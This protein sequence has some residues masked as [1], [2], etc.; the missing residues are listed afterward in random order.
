MHTRS[1]NYGLAGG[2][3]D[4]TKHVESAIKRLC[5]P[6]EKAGHQ[7]RLALLVESTTGVAQRSAAPNN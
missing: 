5:F 4:A 6:E 7:Q 3:L 1:T 2:T